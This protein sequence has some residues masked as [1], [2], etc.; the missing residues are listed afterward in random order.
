MIRQL[1]FEYSAST[2]LSFESEACISGA[3]AR[4]VFIDVSG[5][6]VDGVKLPPRAGNFIDDAVC[7]GSECRAVA[8]R[9]LRA[10]SAL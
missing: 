7:A 8:R 10:Y 4:G 2:T 9:S 3:R 5:G 1:T 6:V